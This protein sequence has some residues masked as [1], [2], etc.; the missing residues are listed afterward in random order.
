DTTRMVGFAGA[1]IA[2]DSAAYTSSCLSGSRRGE[3]NHV[4]FG[5]Y[6]GGQ[7]LGFRLLVLHQHVIVE[8]LRRHKAS[9]MGAEQ[10]VPGHPLFGI[11]AHNP[12]TE[13]VVPVPR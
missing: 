6:S 7:L 2:K 8:R 3:F 11:H 5:V 12:G 4:A 1:V 9:D 10:V 13:A